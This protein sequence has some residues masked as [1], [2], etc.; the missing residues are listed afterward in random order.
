[1]LYNYTSI[2]SRNMFHS[3]ALFFK[4][5]SRAITTCMKPEKTSSSVNLTSFTQINISY[6][7]EPPQNFRMH[8]ESRL[9]RK[10]SFNRGSL[11]MGCF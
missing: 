9:Q 1:M 11:R 2:K 7:V 3:I 6:L 8:S 4:E 10:K 5:F